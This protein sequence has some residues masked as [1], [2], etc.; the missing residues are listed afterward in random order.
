[1]SKNRWDP[2]AR[3]AA[4]ARTDP[5]DAEAD[6]SPYECDSCGACCRSFSIFA[7]REDA[8]REPRIRNAAMP[9]PEHLRTERE[10]Y[11]LFPLP[12]LSAC[13]FL[14]EDA[15]CTIYASRPDVCRGFE[16]GSDQCQQARLQHGLPRLRPGGAVDSDAEGSAPW[17]G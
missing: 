1:M 3:L 15:R 2:F 11:Q 14:G 17:I 9:V 16:A 7:S 10:C 5:P 6:G 8:I 4:R 13:S 12:F